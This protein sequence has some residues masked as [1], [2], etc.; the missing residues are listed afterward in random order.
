MKDIDVFG[1]G[2]PLIDL[3]AHVSDDFLEAQ[4]LEKNRMYLVGF[5]DQ[6]ELLSRLK[7]SGAEV[8]YAPGGSCANSMIGLCQLGAVAAYSGRIGLDKYG[9]IYKEKLTQDRV[10]SSLGEARGA[11]GSS[12]ILVTED[13]A[14][15][16]CSVLNTR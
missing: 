14:S 8:L 13:G 2:N 12:L 1:I 5:E 3:L 16:V 9:R 15:F 6:V 10:K 4:G 7:Q 11:T